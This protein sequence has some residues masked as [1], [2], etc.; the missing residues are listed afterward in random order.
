MAVQYARRD[1]AAILGRKELP[2]SIVRKPIDLYYSSIGSLF[3]GRRIFLDNLRASLARQD[4][5]TG[6]IVGR[7]VHGMGG[8]GK[9]RAAVEYAWA[10]RDDYTALFLLDA[11]TPDKLHTALAALAVPLQLPAATAA[12]EA[13]RFDA[14]L[15]WLNTNPTWLLIFDNIDAGPALAA[16]H[17]LLGLLTGGHVLMTSR[18][19]RFPRGVEGLDLDVLSLDDATSFLLV[20]TQTGRLR[21]PGDPPT[22]GPWPKYLAN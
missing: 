8:V 21:A 10:H 6:A 16:A 13:V 12:E 20:A 22:P 18:L 19:T 7:A 9:T 5:G 14:V 1:V 4:G 2:Y 17:R 3:K 15:D 11:E